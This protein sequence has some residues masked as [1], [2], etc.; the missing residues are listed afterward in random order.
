MNRGWHAKAWAGDEA[1]KAT[2]RTGKQMQ[3]EP[4]TSSLGLRN[5]GTHLRKTRYKRLH[6]SHRLI[7]QCVQI[8]WKHTKTVYIALIPTHS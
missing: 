7:L 8:V 4:G 2:P 3:R 6:M 5:S 1:A